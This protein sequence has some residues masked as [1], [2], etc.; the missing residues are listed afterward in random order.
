MCEET[1]Y[2]IQI[3]SNKRSCQILVPLCN[4]RCSS[5]LPLANLSC[6]TL[7]IVPTIWQ[8]LSIINAFH[9][10]I[11]TACS[12]TITPAVTM[13]LRVRLCRTLFAN[14]MRCRTITRTYFIVSAW[15]MTS[16]HHSAHAASSDI[17][18]I[19]TQEYICHLSWTPVAF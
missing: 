15:C 8:R 19:G 16:S 13:A 5:F 11:A 7:R 1:V 2:V 9:W 10:P 12:M 4:C 6:H 3:H 14:Q 18:F 17:R